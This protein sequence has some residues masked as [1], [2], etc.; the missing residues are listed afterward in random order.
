LQTELISD[1]RL[2]REQFN[3]LF[4]QYQLVASQLF[5]SQAL[6]TFSQI[7]KMQGSNPLAFLRLQENLLKRSLQLADLEHAIFEKYVELLDTSGLS[8]GLPFRDYLNEGLKS[9]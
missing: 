9:F 6:F 3:L 4:K 1:L 8:S 5:E 2:Q 7:A